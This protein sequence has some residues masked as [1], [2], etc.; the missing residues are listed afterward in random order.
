MAPFRRRERL[1]PDFIAVPAESPVREAQIE[2]VDRRLTALKLIPR[3]QRSEAWDAI[4]S[5]LL[6]ERNKIRKGRP[7][8][9]PVIPGRIGSVIDN[10]WENP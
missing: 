1:T 3:N 5:Q 9:V 8:P 6:D 4:A 10:D 2:D 7:V